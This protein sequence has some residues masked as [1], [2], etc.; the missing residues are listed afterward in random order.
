MVLWSPGE[1]ATAEKMNQMGSVMSGSYT[2][3]Y[4]SNRAI[5]HGLGKTPAMVMIVGSDNTV[6]VIIRPGYITRPKSEQSYSVYSPDATNFYVGNSA[7]WMYS[8]NN[9]S[10]TYYWVAIG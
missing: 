6:F 7:N 4:T 3:D 9:G 2:G 1:S 5:A 8:A 10:T